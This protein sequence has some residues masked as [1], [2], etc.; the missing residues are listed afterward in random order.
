MKNWV[1]QLGRAL[2]RR[3]LLSKEEQ[4][5]ALYLVWVSPKEMKNLH[6][7]FCGLAKVTDV[8][9]FDPQEKAICFG[10]VVL[11]PQVIAPRARKARISLSAY[12]GHLILHASLHLLGFHHEP[13]DS[14]PAR[15]MYRVQEEL[16][17]ELWGKGGA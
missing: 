14:P 17:E 7:A 1:T 13:E 2:Y 11:C 4:K 8:L 6:R 3:G 12:T 9:C 5:K 16:F 15:L 10:E